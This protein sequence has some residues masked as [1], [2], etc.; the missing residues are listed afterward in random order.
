MPLISR[1][2]IKEAERARQLEELKQNLFQLVEHRRNLDCV[3]R[4]EI[5]KIAEDHLAIAAS[6]R[7]IYDYKVVTD[8]TLYGCG[9]DDYEIPRM[10]VYLKKTK[11]VEYTVWAFGPPDFTS[12]YGRFWA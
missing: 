4:T 2:Q 6:Y 1:W 7:L 5:R 9:P 10:V 11:S 12:V 8:T 3:E